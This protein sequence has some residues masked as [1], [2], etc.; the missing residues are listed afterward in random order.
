VLQSALITSNGKNKI[1]VTPEMV[2]KTCEI[3]VALF[4][5]HKRDMGKYN[6][7]MRTLWHNLGRNERLRRSVL[8]SKITGIKLCEMSSSDLATEEERKKREKIRK[9]YIEE[10]AALKGEDEDEDDDEDSNE[11]VVLSNSEKKEKKKRDE[12]TEKQEDLEQIIKYTTGALEDLQRIR[13]GVGVLL[14]ND[15]EEMDTVAVELFAKLCCNQAANNDINR[16]YS[17]RDGWDI[18]K[19]QHDIYASQKKKHITVS[20]SPC[21]VESKPDEKIEFLDAD[22]TN[23]SFHIEMRKMKEIMNGYV[24]HHDVQTLTLWPEQGVIDDGTSE[25]I[26]VIS[27]GVCVC[28]CVVVIL[29]LLITL[30]F[31]NKQ[32]TQIE[33]ESRHGLK[34]TEEKVYARLR[35]NQI[36]TSIRWK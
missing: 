11:S 34:H 35:S 24:T 9:T 12:E 3:E 25:V 4:E 26:K 19:L 20:T 7:H 13:N 21:V 14:N 32:R 8:N 15:H 29:Y 22:G 1:K 28:V 36:R 31:N 33:N 27:K 5:K 16:Y 17:L 6:Q 10:K 2:A 18:V 30:I 23:I